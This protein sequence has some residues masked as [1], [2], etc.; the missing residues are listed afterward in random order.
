MIL[1]VITLCGVLFFGHSMA[2]GVC[3][4]ACTDNEYCI[5]HHG[6][7]CQHCWGSPKICR[8]YPPPPPVSTN[9]STY[10][11]ATTCHRKAHCEW[12]GS[13]AYPTV[14]V[15]FLKNL[16]LKCCPSLSISPSIQCPIHQKCMNNYPAS[17]YFP[18]QT[19]GP[20]CCPSNSLRV[21][22]GWGPELPGTC[23]ASTNCCAA[24]G[25][26]GEA[27]C[28]AAGDGCC[29][30]DQWGVCVGTDQFCCQADRPGTCTKGK[31]ICCM[32]NVNQW[33]CPIGTKCSG[34]FGRCNK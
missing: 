11:S 22:P 12:C 19:M 28:C 26:P 30:G 10:T 14:G 9:C 21:C 33:C 31:E 34:D 32:G 27:A 25:Y 13:P 3:H 23:C 17:A 6:S 5:A 8:E 20:M 24:N 15:C 16:T 29:S 7:S 2:F 18:N 4:E 1:R